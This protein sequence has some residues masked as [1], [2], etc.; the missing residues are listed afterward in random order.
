MRTKNSSIR[1]YLVAD[2]QDHHKINKMIK[3]C[4]SLLLS[5]SLTEAVK[6]TS[7]HNGADPEVIREF[8]KFQSEMKRNYPT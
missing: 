1:L 2:L 8:A 3:I 5:I 4:I 7:K 6:L